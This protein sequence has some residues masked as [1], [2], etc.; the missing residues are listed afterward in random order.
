[1][2]R[3]LDIGRGPVVQ[4][5]AMLLEGT[6][7]EK[8]ER[9]TRN[10]QRTWLYAF[11]ADKSFGITTGRATC[12]FWKELPPDVSVW[13]QKPGASPHDRMICGIVEMRIIVVSIVVFLSTD[14][15]LDS[16]RFWLTSSR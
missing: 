12:F 1:M 3:E 16:C 2:A 15:T 9:L 7:S 4:Q 5:M 8:R 6:N 11:I 10:M 14:G 13:W